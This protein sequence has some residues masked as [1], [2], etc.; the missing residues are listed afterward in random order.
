[1]RHEAL[2]RVS[3][4]G[5]PEVARNR[6]AT[7]GRP[8]ERVSAP[9]ARLSAHYN[10]STVDQHAVDMLGAAVAERSEDLVCAYL[11]GSYACGTAGAQSDVDVAVRFA[12]EPTCT[13]DCL[14]LDPADDLAGA[15]G[16]RVDLVVLNRAP[17]DLIHRVLRDGVPLIA[18]DRSARIRFEVR[19]RK[20]YVELPPHL[21]R[22]R[23]A[24]HA[25]G[26]RRV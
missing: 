11:F 19:A 2:R 8:T 21:Q 15:L 26:G 24:G 13:L 6:F 4:P 14:H 3:H 16:R 20:D 18:H 23:R 7:S 10:S 22:Y 5:R 25:G 17:V 1:M 9:K 12:S